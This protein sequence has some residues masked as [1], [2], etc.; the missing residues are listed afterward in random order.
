MLCAH[1]HDDKKYYPFYAKNKLE[2]KP[3]VFEECQLQLKNKKGIIITGKKSCQINRSLNEAYIII[4]FQYCNISLRKIRCRYEIYPNLTMLSKCNSNQLSIWYLPKKVHIRQTKKAYQS[5]S[6]IKMGR[7]KKC[8]KK[9][10]CLQIWMV[11]IQYYHFLDHC[12]MMEFHPQRYL[13]FLDIRNSLSNH[14]YIFHA[15]DVLEH[16][17]YYGIQCNA[18]NYFRMNMIL[19]ENI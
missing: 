13:I 19:I 15:T 14:R 4:S 6:P 12:L 2:Q 8:V 9:K 11:Y 10:V 18:D 17:Y 5:L 1:F 7:N 16:L 3:C